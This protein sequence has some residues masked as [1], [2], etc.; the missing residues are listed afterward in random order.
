[1][2][3]IQVSLFGS[4]VRTQHWSKFF[5]QLTMN[6]VKYEVIFAGPV[7]P[8]YELPPNVRH[9][10]VDP[11]PGTVH[12]SGIAARECQGEIMAGIADDVV[13]SPY[14]LDYMYET[15]K[16]E[17]DYKCMVHARYGFGPDSDVTDINSELPIPGS[18]Y[19]W[20][21][22][23]MFSR[24]FFFE[25][26]GYDDRYIGGAGEGDL[27]CR[28]FSQGGRFVYANN[29]YVQEDLSYVGGNALSESRAWARWGGRRDNDV[30]KAQWFPNGALL[31]EPT[32]PFRPMPFME[33]FVKVPFEKSTEQ[34]VT[35]HNEQKSIPTIG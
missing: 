24:Q 32:T 21:F 29:A 5:N 30:M 17:N 19:R 28:A 22:S 13:L 2:S 7:I 16:K 11:D 10:H 31:K 12:C 9:I 34:Q 8:E 27:Q 1:M 20:G 18:P 33:Q 4:A 3:D 15:Y 14:A 35:R 25:L 23:V 26:G 6:K